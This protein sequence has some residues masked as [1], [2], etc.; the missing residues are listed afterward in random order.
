MSTQRAV[1]DRIADALTQVKGA[2]SLVFLTEGALIAVR[3]PMGIRPLVLG[4]LPGSEL[5]K[6]VASE[7]TEFGLIDAKTVRD[8]APGDRVLID[9]HGVR[10]SSPFRRSPPPRVVLDA[11]CR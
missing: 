1:E 2:Y 5:P 7:R 10:T 4:N 3:D 9:K 6:G 8:I 11:V